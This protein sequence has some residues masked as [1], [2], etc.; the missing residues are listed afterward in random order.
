MQNLKKIK[1]GI[2]MTSVKYKSKTGEEP[3]GQ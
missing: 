3:R 1:I 2:K